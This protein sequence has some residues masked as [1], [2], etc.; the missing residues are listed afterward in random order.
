M[1]DELKESKELWLPATATLLPERAAKGAS[2]SAG[3]GTPVATDEVY[4]EEGGA[5]DDV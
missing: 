5:A 1:S 3:S 4:A 2:G